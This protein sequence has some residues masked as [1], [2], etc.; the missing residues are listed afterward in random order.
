MT[1]QNTQKRWL[2]LNSEH[3]HD[4]IKMSLMDNGDWEY[5]RLGIGKTDT[6]WFLVDVDDTGED[7]RV[8]NMCKEG[9]NLS[10]ILKIGVKHNVF[11]K[12]DW[13]YDEQDTH[14]VNVNVDQDWNWEGFYKEVLVNEEFDEGIED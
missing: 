7:K 5:D 11:E 1:K 13:G 14:R 2:D 6:G 9:L 4:L 12:I 8:M 3:D 10:K